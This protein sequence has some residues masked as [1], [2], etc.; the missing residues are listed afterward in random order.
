MNQ[1]AGP[2][3]HLEVTKSIGGSMPNGEGNGARL[4]SWKDIATYLRRDVRTAIRWE[5]D[6]GL[7]VR[8]VPGGQRQAVFAYTAELDAWLTQE[9]GEPQGPK[10]GSSPGLS[11]ATEATPVPSGSGSTAL[12]AGSVFEADATA[13]RPS[14]L[15]WPHYLA[16]AI[17]A[18]IFAA[19]AIGFESRTQAGAGTLPVRV[20]FTLN[21]L[22]AFDADDR[23]IWSY[24]LPGLFAPGQSQGD[25]RRLEDLTRIGDFRG[26]GEREILA[27]VNVRIGPNAIAPNHSEV[28]LLSS[29][30]KLLWSYVPHGRLLFSTHDLKDGWYVLDVFVS[31]R[32]GKKQIWVAVDHSVWG[33]SF[34]VSLDPETGKDTLRY[35]NSGTTFALNELAT[36]QRN[37]LLAGGFNNEYDSGTLAVIDESKDFAVS[38]QTEGT[39][40]KCLNCAK[41]DLEY[42]F[43]FPRSEINELVQFYE[44]RV[45]SVRVSGDEI[46]LLK[47]ETEWADRAQSFYSLKRDGLIHPV[48]VLFDT[49]YEL[50]HNKFE[51]EGKIDHNLA[52]C[53]ERLHPRPIRMWTPAGGWTEIHLEPGRVSN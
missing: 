2:K 33:H 4:D 53:P 18:A 43:V 16:L 14:R 5:K 29:S 50:L 40:H 8:R 51:R 38:P 45:I 30:G 25:G 42:Y 20:S 19:L 3:K 13:G 24:P 6:K 26:D 28:D 47:K 1:A 36:P 46:E 23:I 52:N 22:Q 37:F 12:V 35:V 9:L 15:R 11:G 21:A 17:A 7:P 39:S 31:E 48:S 27:G 10:P 49:S 41:G 34:I 44:D 32:Q